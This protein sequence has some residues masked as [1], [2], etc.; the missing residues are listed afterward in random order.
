MVNQTL[1]EKLGY[2]KT[3]KVVIFHIDDI[4]FSHSSNIASFECLDYGIASCGSI[5]A[6]SSWLL[7]VASIYKKNLIP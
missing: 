1:N 4:G 5:I 6:P 3:D 7:E 2:D